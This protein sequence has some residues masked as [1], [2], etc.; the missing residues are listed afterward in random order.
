MIG[1]YLG[2]DMTRA[3]ALEA[4]HF[5]EP[6]INEVV[7]GL[8]FE[9]LKELLAPHLGVLWERYKPTFASC[10]ELAPLAIQFEMPVGTAAEAEILLTEI[11]PLPRVW[12]EETNG[13]G[14]IQ[15]Q[16]DRFHYNWRR[17]S[18]DDEYPHFDKVFAL[19]KAKLEIFREFVREIRPDELVPK[20][21]EITYVNHIPLGKGWNS[22][23]DMGNVFPDFS[24]KQDK[25]RMQPES[26]NWR[27]SFTLPGGVGRLHATVRSGRSIPDNKPI[28]LF[29]ITARGIGEDRTTEGMKRWFVEAHNQI[30]KAFVKMTTPEMQAVWKLQK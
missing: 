24:W 7:C 26:V 5:E 14:V 13:N 21:L 27:V 4:L 10:K 17:I 16:R 6:P 3:A 29:D 11:P 18:A 19:F 22:V 25:E 28:L 1:N 20:Q 8:M 2:Y 30:V 9:P 23:T 15:V 12:F